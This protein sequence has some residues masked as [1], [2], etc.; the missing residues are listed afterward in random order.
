[1]QTQSD[2]SYA[3]PGLYDIKDTLQQFLGQPKT[4]NFRSTSREAWGSHVVG[5][6]DKVVR[7]YR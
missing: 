1:M 4:Y 3:L 5:R 7:P 6:K 2:G